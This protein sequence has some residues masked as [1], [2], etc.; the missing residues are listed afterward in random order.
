MLEAGVE[1]Y[2]FH[3]TMLHQNAVQRIWSAQSPLLAVETNHPQHSK[4][5][6]DICLW[7]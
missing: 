1:I 5:L 6:S 4:C 3:P 2:E 7:P